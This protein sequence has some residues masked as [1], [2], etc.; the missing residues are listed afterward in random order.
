MA[1]VVEI[2]E[3]N[4][5]KLVGVGRLIADPDHE[6]VE[7]AILITDAWQ[8]KNLGNILTSYCIEISKKLG[9]KRIIAETSADNKPM[10]LIFRK[11]KFSIHF[12]GNSTVSVSKE[13]Y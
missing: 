5:R 1:I 8:N 6:T 9:L 13:L 10:I 7:Y 3:N 11:F 12:I 4:S 2:T